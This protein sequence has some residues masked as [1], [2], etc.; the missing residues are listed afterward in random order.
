[1]WRGKQVADAIVTPKN[2]GREWAADAPSQAPY[3][4]IFL[5]LSD[6]IL[7]G[8]KGIALAVLAVFL[9]TD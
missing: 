1:M 7:S 3:T 8:R 9:S 6:A 4:V 2:K 5:S